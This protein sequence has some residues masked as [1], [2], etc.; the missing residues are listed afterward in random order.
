MRLPMP[1]IE[2]ASN[3]NLCLL[4]DM[5]SHAYTVSLVLYR[6]C[7][8]FSVRISAMYGTIISSFTK[9]R[10][11][12]SPSSPAA[13]H[14]RTRC[15]NST[16]KTCRLHGKQYGSPM[17]V[18]AEHVGH[19]AQT[20]FFL[21]PLLFICCLYIFSNLWS[22]RLFGFV[23][24]CTSGVSQCVID[25]DELHRPCS[26]PLNPISYKLEGELEK[27]LEGELE[28]DLEGEY[29][30][31]PVLMLDSERKGDLDVRLEAVFDSESDQQSTSVLSTDVS[32]ETKLIYLGYSCIYFMMS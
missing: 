8:C 5:N 7:A 24:I 32:I 31:K 20:S 10:H 19:C 4:G 22:L 15:K 28:T 9:S 29:V 18:V 2:Q 23:S 25:A 26:A 30:S 12:Y 17:L 6:E 27:D 16:P 11:A 13:F 21:N 14:E 1:R 3:R